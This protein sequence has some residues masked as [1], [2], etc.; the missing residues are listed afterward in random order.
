[1]PTDGRRTLIMSGAVHYARVPM[2]D[3][4]AVLADAKAMGLNAIQTYFM[5]NFHERERGVL[6]WT[7]RR[8]LTHFIQLAHDA[9]LFVTLRIGPYVCGEYQFGG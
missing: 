4:A 2:Q 9:G 3:W 6:D 1:M 7:G 8:N 5:W